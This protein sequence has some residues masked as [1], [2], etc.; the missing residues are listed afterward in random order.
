MSGGSF[1][2]LCYAQPEELFNRISDME[3]MER[4]L[5]QRGYND[6]AKDVRRLIE[7]CLSA[8]NRIGVFQEKLE[9]VFHSVEWFESGDIGDASLAEALEGYRK[10][11]EQN[12]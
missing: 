10:G 4:F 12:G 3:E 7:Y 5:L 11:S 9:D 1:N 2:Y 6:I 8:K